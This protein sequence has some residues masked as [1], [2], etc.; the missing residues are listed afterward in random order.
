MSERSY[1]GATSRSPK[2]DTLV[3]RQREI[4]AAVLS[5]FSAEVIEGEVRLKIVKKGKKEREKERENE[6]KR[7]K[8]KERKTERKKSHL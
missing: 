2:G 7:K 5:V 6:R 8:E 3:G 1:H 4:T